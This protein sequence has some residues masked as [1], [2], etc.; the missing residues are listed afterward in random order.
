[1]AQKENANEYRSERKERLAKQAKKKANKQ[2]DSTRAASAVIIVIAIL[3]GIAAIGGG[4]YAYGVPQK[5]LPAVKVE[6]RTYTVAEYGYYYASVYQT[7]ANQSYS[8]QQ[9]YGFSIGFD[10]T[11]DPASQTTTD[12]DGN[13]ITYAEFFENYVVETLEQYNYY[14]GKAE[15]AGITLS[16]ENKK[17]IDDTIAEIESYASQYGYS[18]NRYISVL[19]GKGLNEKK[20]RSLLEEQSIVSQYIESLTSEADSAITMEDIEA[21]YAE[22]A[23]DYKQVDIRL[24]G[25]EIG[26]EEAAAETETEEPASADEAE[27]AEASETETEAETEEAAAE[28]ETEAAAEA[29]TEAAADDETTAAEEETTEKEKSAQELL[30]EEMLAKVTDEDSFVELAKE[31][32]AEADKATF[33]NDGATNAIGLKKS[34]ISNNI[35]SDLADWLFSEERSA[36]DKRTYITDKYAYVILMKG[37]AY[38]NETPL[39]N[40]RH[41]LVSFDNVKNELEAAAAAEEEETLEGIEEITDEAPE[42]AAPEAAAEET[43]AEAA[44]ETTAESAADGTE[45]TAAETADTAEVDTNAEG[46]GYSAEV[47][48]EAYKKAKDIYNEYMDGE[49]TE[50]AFAALAEKYS[51]DTASLSS[52]ENATTEGG[53]YENITKGS[54]VEEFENWVYDEARQPGDVEVIK[55]SYGYHVMYFVSTNEEAEWISSIRSDIS[56][57][58]QT[59]IEDNVKE[60]TKGTAAP[61]AFESFAAKS[62]LKLINKLYVSNASNG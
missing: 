14:L 21:R 39:V 23:D 57:E 6:D 18:A 2:H 42:A 11:K 38:R 56:S 33:E 16:E 59:E 4:L 61:A 26:A 36:G 46:T 7:Y 37:P 10:H 22:K 41:I 9:Q 47:V 54:M 50:E 19:Y 49:K 35:G 24:F 8:Y 5:I 62:A 29:E 31:Y 60:L 53:L 12:A 43:T 58:K 48:L 13:T 27:A 3:A 55:T 51:A 28:A 34:T 25:L 1:M 40:A 30:C 32:C 44:E 45:E 17:S 15:E 20:L 52:A